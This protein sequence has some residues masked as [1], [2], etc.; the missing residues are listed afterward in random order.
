MMPDLP[1]LTFRAERV[2]FFMTFVQEFVICFFY[3]SR[4]NRVSKSL[5]CKVS[6]IN[7]SS[8]AHAPTFHSLHVACQGCTVPVHSLPRL[9][10]R[11]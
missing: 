9:Q 4:W 8:C 7:N 11:R 3:E 6:C 5:H 10:I 1:L 2:G